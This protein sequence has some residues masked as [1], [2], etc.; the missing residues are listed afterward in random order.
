MKHF[1][2][3]ISGAGAAGLMLA[4]RMAKDPFFNHKSIALIDIEKKKSNDR[5]WCFWENGKGEWD[6]LLATSWEN[7]FFG[8]PGYEKRL[9]INPYIYKMIRSADFYSAIWKILDESSNFIFIQG[10]VKRIS[11]VSESVHVVTTD[12]IFSAGKVFN[13]IT[14]DREF[15][16]QTRYPLLQQHFVG[17][18]IKTNGDHFDEKMATFMDFRVPQRNNTRFMYL[19]PMSK[20]TALLEY[21]LFSEKLLN[22]K[23]YEDEIKAYLDKHGISDYTILETEKGSIP[24]TAYDFGK[25]NSQ[26]VLNIG[27]A[28]GW[29]KA[30]TGYTFMNTTKKSTAL[31]SFLKNENN[32]SKFSKKTKFWFYDLILLD[33][34]TKDNHLG[35]MLFTGLFKKTKATTIL[36]FLDEETSFQEDLKIIKSMPVLRFTK[37]LFLRLFRL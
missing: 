1:D 2:Y 34:L 3:V 21:T 5:T 24:M 14:L 17:W 18:F 29:T 36:K 16:Q 28:G 31:I 25:H 8:G 10:Q 7:I 27:T 22:I 15:E 35:S 12:E 23:E 19:L 9:N 6:D 37:A 32:F 20:N 4:F 13:S 33:V 11:D 30:S 26:N